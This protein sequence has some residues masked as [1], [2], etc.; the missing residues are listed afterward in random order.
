MITMSGALDKFF[1]EQITSTLESLMSEEYIDDEGQAF[2]SKLKEGLDIIKRFQ[3]ERVSEE[4]KATLILQLESIQLAM[5]NYS[6]KDRRR[7][8]SHENLPERLE[9]IGLLNAYQKWNE[10]LTNDGFVLNN[11]IEEE[12]MGFKTLSYRYNG[13]FAVEGDH[14][15]DV[16]GLSARITENGLVIEY[17]SSKLS[18]VYLG[19]WDEVEPI[20][21][22][23]GIEKIKSF[24]DKHREFIGDYCERI[25]VCN[26]GCFQMHFD[27]DAHVCLSYYARGT[28]IK[29]A[30]LLDKEL[31]KRYP[32]ENIKGYELRSRVKLVQT[33]EDFEAFKPSKC[34]AYRQIRNHECLRH[35][36]LLDIIIMSSYQ[37]TQE[38]ALE[39][40]NE[41]SNALMKLRKKQR[42]YD[43]QFGRKTDLRPYAVTDDGKEY[44]EE[45]YIA[46]LVD[47]IKGMSTKEFENYKDRLFDL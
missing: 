19:C 8:V 35:Q 43:E 23:E 20:R 25:E 11:V 21:D 10:E 14:A 17:W 36:N 37:I 38:E 3:E 1:E 29:L 18:L 4:E 46:S 27:N 6:F 47:E 31:R 7:Q 24:L 13:H 39:K 26:D 32:F 9:E 16:F 45:E 34:M 15:D 22:L 42:V 33:V 2:I 12:L 30:V 40:F 5:L 44:S 41:L 28:F